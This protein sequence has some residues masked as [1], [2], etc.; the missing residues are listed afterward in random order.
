M[1][2]YLLITKK[3]AIYLIIVMI[4]SFF[5]LSLP[6]HSAIT[7]ECSNCHTMHNSQNG[8][9]MADYGATGQPWKGTGPYE[10]LTRGDCLGCHGIGTS[11]IVTIGGSEIPQVYHTSAADDL[12]GGN[13]AYILGTKGS[14]ASDAKGHNVTDLGN[15]D[16]TLDYAPGWFP[17]EHDNAVTSNNLTCAGSIGCHG[18]RGDPDAMGVPVIKGSHHKNVS[19]KLDIAD[20]VYNSYRFLRGVKGYENDGTYKWQNKDANNHNEYF[21]ATTPANIG[22]SAQ[23][24]HTP[25]GVV[26]PN[27]TMS[28]F[29]ATCHGSFHVVGDADDDII[30]EGIG[31]DTSSP[32]TRHPTDV[33]LPGGT[34]EYANYN[35][36]GGNLFSVE[37][38]VARGV[39]PDSISS[40]VIPGDSGAEGAIVMCLSCHKAHASDY[41]D[42]LRWDYNTIIAG[43]GTN[44][45]GCFVCHTTKDDGQ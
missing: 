45:T 39:V 27:N 8:S 3:I 12:A 43:G 20:D 21:G 23:S 11:N 34:T 26:P 5:A 9:I 37:A 15:L 22:C 25:T 24:C 17:R 13:F 36:A 1:G 16:D 18:N 7:G 42:M 6:A 31:G 4:M 28:G 32:F 10:A 19:G 40:V 35:P 33:I 41:P 38:P 14:G 44:G 29:C 30:D 2:D